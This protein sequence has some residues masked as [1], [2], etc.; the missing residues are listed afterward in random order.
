MILGFNN[1]FTYLAY[2]ILANSTFTRTYAESSKASDIFCRKGEVKIFNTYFRGIEERAH[3]CFCQMIT[4]A[5]ASF[6]HVAF[7][8]GGGSDASSV[9]SMDG[10]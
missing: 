3:N 6:D 10:N 8:G 7:V 4:K 1:E 5:I 2:A 9:F